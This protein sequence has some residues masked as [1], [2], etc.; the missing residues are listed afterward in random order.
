MQKSK[1][2]EAQTEA[3]F[4]DRERDQRFRSFWDP[5]GSLHWGYFENL[6]KAR[7]EDFVPACKRW[8]EY[9][10]AQSG[11]TADSRVLEVAC[12]NG[13]AAVWL[14]QQ[15]GCEVVGIDISSSYIENA[16]AKASNF[17]S[18]RVSFQKESALNLPFPDGSFTHAWSQG[19]LYHIHE[20]EK[21]L[22]EVYRVLGAGGIF[23]FDD[24]VTPVQEISETAR[25]YVYDRQRVDPTYSPEVYT[26]KL[27]QIGF[28]VLQVKEMSEHLKKS[29]ELVSELA[30]EAYPDL[31][32]AFDKTQ[33]AITARELGWCFYLCD[34]VSDH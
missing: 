30:R 18:L 34:K 10:L 21:A 14:A 3:L 13:N 28:N 25:K 33:E 5:E 6:A 19:A 16:R 17:P 20:R 31:S 8:D 27:T 11:I 22:A 15:T 4:D 1:F 2:T 29:Y 32:V 26:E 23:L 7:P 24:L 9:M 12:G